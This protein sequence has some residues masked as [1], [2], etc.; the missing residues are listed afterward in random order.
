MV[1]DR[2]AVRMVEDLSLIRRHSHPARDRE[3]L[4]C[5]EV[6]RRHEISGYLSIEALG[7]FI[8]ILRVLIDPE[9]VSLANLGLQ[10][11]RHPTLSVGNRL[12]FVA[13][14][15]LPRLR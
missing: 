1:L 3:N 13:H 12:Y 14:R 5:V 2:E 4:V 11:H 9:C 6:A 15:L 8:R 10:R 7:C